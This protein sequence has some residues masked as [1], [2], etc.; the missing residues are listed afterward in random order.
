MTAPEVAAP[1]K[2][3]EVAPDFTLT[4]TS[5]E[6][7]TLSAHRGKESVLLCFFPF[8]FSGVCTVEFC[9]IRDAYS[10][11][12][13]RG[14]VVYPISVDSTYALREFKAKHGMQVELLSDF[15]RTVSA[16]YGTLYADKGFSNR[17]YV[18]IDAGG[19]VRW[20]Q[21]EPNPGSKRSSAE[22]LAELAKLG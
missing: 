9:E 17:A 16:R 10:E 11:F 15:M 1:P 8:A 7:V 4:S 18:L 19:I 12:A 6:P 13:S 5:G 2:V 14:V 22:V 3:G 20:I 21:V